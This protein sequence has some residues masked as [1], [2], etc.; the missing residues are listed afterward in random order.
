MKQFLTICAIA[1]FI[2]IL[3]LPIAY[4]TFLR[5]IVSLGA[6]VLIYNFFKQKNYSLTVVFMV[7]L[8]LFNPILP[9]YLHRKSIWIPLDVITGL[10][11]LIISY[12]EKKE[13]VKEEKATEVMTVS[14]T[15]TRDRIV[16]AKKEI[17]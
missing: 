15:Y 1:C 3:R 8:L 12:Y 9:V 13:P 6:I 10:L 7:V 4:Y 5:A 2:A 11:F 17:K 16:S 14:K